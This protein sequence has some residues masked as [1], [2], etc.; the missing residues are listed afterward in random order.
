MNLDIVNV[1]KD[2]YDYAKYIQPLPMER[3]SGESIQST[4]KDTFEDSVPTLQELQDIAL[5]HIADKLEE[6]YK[7]LSDIS[8]A[9]CHDCKFKLRWIAIDLYDFSKF[10]MPLP[11]ELET[12]E[13]ARDIHK[14]D[15]LEEDSSFR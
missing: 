8:E 6:H 12:R 2:L 15:T 5:G 10:L 9:S 3:M 7:E 1:A 13:L 14:M 4:E 11:M